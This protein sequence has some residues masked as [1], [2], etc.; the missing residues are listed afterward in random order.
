MTQLSYTCEVTE[1]KIK[2]VEDSY[3]AHVTRYHQETFEEYSQRLLKRAMQNSRDNYPSSDWARADYEIVAFRPVK[4]ENHEYYISKDDLSTIQIA[5]E[6]TVLGYMS[7]PEARLIL[8][9]KPK[10]RSWIVRET[11]IKRHAKKGDIVRAESSSGET[12]ATI[13]TWISHF[14]SPEPLDIV[15]IEEI[16]E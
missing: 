1:T 8:K 3:G 5:G 15:T 16:T 6:G 10:L 4:P 9:R 11:G 14:N 2:S 13:Y 12:Y 7:G